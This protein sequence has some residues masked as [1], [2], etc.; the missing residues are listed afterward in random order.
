MTTAYSP[1]PGCFVAPSFKTNID[2]TV[3]SVHEDSDIEDDRMAKNGVITQQCSNLDDVLSI[4]EKLRI[5]WFITLHHFGVDIKSQ[6]T[7][8]GVIR[9]SAGNTA[10]VVEDERHPL[11]DFLF[12]SN[13]AI[14]HTAL[15]SSLQLS[16]VT[17]TVLNDAWNRRTFA[18]FFELIEDGNEVGDQGILT[19]GTLLIVFST[20]VK[21]VLHAM[22]NMPRLRRPGETHALIGL[23]RMIALAYLYRL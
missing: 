20:H 10:D 18:L 6:S 8:W 7:K 21:F 14:T 11:P 17:R 23:M 22:H 13:T 12:L 19:L 1:A 3:A 16:D 15:Q 5:S 9:V 2:I 4:V